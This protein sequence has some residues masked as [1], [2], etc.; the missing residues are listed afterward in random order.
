MYG[1]SL[2]L[3][4]PGVTLREILAFR[5]ANGAYGGPTPEDYV[6]EE[7][8]SAESG[9]ASD[10]VVQLLDGRFIA[11]ECRPMPH[12][13]WVATHEDIT[14][15]RRAE[16]AAIK[17]RTEAERAEADARIAH[18]R[19]RA[20]F[21]VMPEGMVL[22]DTEDRYVLWNKRYR[23]LYG[24]SD[25]AVGARFED[26]VRAGLARGQYPDAVG[27]EEAWLQVRLARFKDGVSSHEQHLPNGRW[28]RVE[29][30]RLADGGA[31]GV[32]VDIT[33]L[34]RR[35]GE[36]REQ[37]ARFDAA[38]SNMS[39]GLCLLDADQRVV[40][41]N[42]RYADLYGLS[43]EHIAPGTPLRQILEARVAQ[44][45]Y[46][47]VDAE[48]F[49]NDGLASFHQEVSNVVDLADGRSIAVLSKPLANGGLISTHE[50]ITARR[51]MEARIA[52]MAHHDALT[53]LPNRV[54]LRERID[55]VL[56]SGLQG[57]GLAILSLDLDRFKEVNDTL[58]H[59]IGDA[60]LKAVAVRL[61]GCVRERDLVARLGGDEFAIVQV[62]SDPPRD[63]AAL[64]ARVIDSVAAP[65]AI[66]GHQL[67]IGTS[68]GIALA[69]ADGADL[70][71]LLKNSDLALYG[72]KADGRGA[73]RFFEPEMNARMQRRRAL[74]ADLRN[75]LENGELALHYQPL[76]DLD[77][78]E[79]SG[80]EALLRWNHPGRGRV[81]PADFIPAAE[82]SGLIVP[83]G[84]WAL[85]Q[86]C[87]EAATWPGDLKVSV[88]L[89]AIQF[90]ARN[91]VQS[92][93]AALGDSGLAPDRLELEITESVLLGRYGRNTR[94]AQAIA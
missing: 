61:R 94:H 11:V 45:V 51:R 72:A 14:H 71:S 42:Q 35:E 55:R 74:E 62:T 67:V 92:V 24:D 1:L 68:I 89:S 8:A 86:A 77:R 22:F 83:I 25:I 81:S 15:L 2:D 43:H 69:P 13:G 48:K 26:V 82:G 76:L 93:I 49:V 50:D 59:A 4:K 18:A 10:K 64:A 47:D 39:Q 6:W 41:A 60:L 29:E 30:R 19:L 90:K 32:R 17:A 33:E 36:L 44:G 21:E 84:E 79:I 3:V 53:D 66:D 5:I 58:G 56:K 16:M 34:K 12:G 80:C 40:I 85:R 65:H 38:L 88:N 9:E 91:L 78:D 28:V 20:A 31:I 75:A 37:N 87:R 63:A 70:E 46:G 27:R 23:A 52:H 73:Y 57:Q 7:V 54:A